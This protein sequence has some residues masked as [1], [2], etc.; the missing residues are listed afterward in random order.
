MKKTPEPLHKVKLP[1]LTLDLPK[2]YIEVCCPSCNNP[3]AA[4][5][6]NIHDKVAKCTQC[7][8]LFPIHEEI[9]NLGQH[10]GSGNNTASTVKNLVHRPVGIDIFRYKGELDFTFKEA[11]NLLFLLI[12]LSFL[13]FAGLTTFISFMDG[14]S[15]LL[16]IGLWILGILMSLYISIRTKTSLNIDKER[17]TIKKRPK[18]W[19]KD[20]AY[21]V[22][23]IDQAYI[24]KEPDSNY[25]SVYLLVNSIVGQKH[26]HLASFDARSK[27]QYL[28]QEIENHLGIPDRPVPEAS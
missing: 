2:N 28:E 21:S 26:V 14:K 5:D 24:K 11:P 19:S 16:P 23:E 13:V 25:Y 4:A 15:F 22:Q 17:L 27:A 3:T 18:I 9:N 6:M 8:V 20:I 1:E 12:A 7:N 10:S